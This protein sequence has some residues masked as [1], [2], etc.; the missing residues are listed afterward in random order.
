MSATSGA[1][2]EVV[3][4]FASLELSN[5]FDEMTPP[6]AQDQSPAVDMQ[7][8]VRVRFADVASKTDRHPHALD[9]SASLKRTLAQQNYDSDDDERGD[10][11]NP[12]PQH[13]QALEKLDDDTAEDSDDP[14]T[15]DDVD[16]GNQ[17]QQGGEETNDRE[18]S[19][20]RRL[21]HSD[22]PM[23]RYEDFLS[24]NKPG[25]QGSQYFFKPTARTTFSETRRVRNSV[26]AQDDLM[27]DGDD[28]VVNLCSPVVTSK[29]RAFP[30]G[31]S[32]RPNKAGVK[33]LKWGNR[34]FDQYFDLLGS[35]EHAFSLS[36][37]GEISISGTQIDAMG[38]LLGSLISSGSSEKKL[39]KRPRFVERLTTVQEQEDA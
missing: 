18:M 20:A 6:L 27:A 33:S 29:F 24:V 36:A 14:N 22:E 26:L 15:D 39:P 13:E 8:N 23:V 37:T 31:R 35:L 28:D 19:P 34:Q 5:N 10:N 32:P 1:C 38:Q 30:Q 4:R 2:S 3:A 21:S 12:A 16:A 7:R 11:Q 25:Q 9:L 17:E